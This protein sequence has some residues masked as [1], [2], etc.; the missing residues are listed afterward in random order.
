[1]QYTSIDQFLADLPALAEEHRTALAGKSARFLFDFKQGRRIFVTLENGALTL[2][3]EEAAAPEA[4][5]LADEKDLLAML[6]GKLN[7]MKAIM[8]GKVKIK[9]NPKPLLELI[10][11]IR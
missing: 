4:T 11:L 9:G 8:L 7:P 6:A 10:A 5:I 2:S 1:M 3:Q